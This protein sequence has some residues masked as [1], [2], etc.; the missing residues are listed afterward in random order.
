MLDEDY[1]IRLKETMEKNFIIIHKWGRKNDPNYA[2]Q[3]AKIKKMQEHKRVLEEM[4]KKHIELCMQDYEKQMLIIR[5]D[6]ITKKTYIIGA[7]DKDCVK[8]GTA[9]NVSRRLSQLN[10]SNPDKLE[11]IFWACTD[12]SEYEYAKPWLEE[13]KLHKECKQYH[14]NKEWYHKDVVNYIDLKHEIF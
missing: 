4:D 3:M 9:K 10:T 8:I 6:N 14:I 12:E 5:D 2:K 11:I 7:K 1:F 13:K